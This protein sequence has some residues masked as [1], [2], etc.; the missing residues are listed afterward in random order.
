MRP[1]I[2]DFDAQTIT[3]IDNRQ[4]TVTVKKFNDVGAAPDKA[5]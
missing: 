4:K 1:S 5:T 3:T 2:L